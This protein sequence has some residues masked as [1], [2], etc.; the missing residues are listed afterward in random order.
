MHTI[1]L[2]HLEVDT[3]SCVLSHLAHLWQDMPLERDATFALAHVVL[4]LGVGKFI[5]GLVSPV[6]W[7]Q[8]LYC[9]IGQM[10]LRLEVMNVEMVG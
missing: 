5:V 7:V 6:V 2:R 9:V 3:A 4:K 8:L 1:E 10:D